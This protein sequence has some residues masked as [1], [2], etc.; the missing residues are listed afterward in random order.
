MMDN[1]E[2]STR[3]DTSQ[4]NT[5]LE[6]NKKPRMDYTEEMNNFLLGYESVPSWAEITKQFNSK[7]DMDMNQGAL[8]SHRNRMKNK[9]LSVQSSIA[10][11]SDSRTK[12]NGSIK[13][14][15]VTV[16][17]QVPQQTK[18]S[19]TFATTSTS[20]GEPSTDESHSSMHSNETHLEEPMNDETHLEEPMNDETHLEEP[21]NDETHFGE[22]VESLNVDKHLVL[23]NIAKRIEE[24]HSSAL[25]AHKVQKIVEHKDLCFSNKDFEMLLRILGA[26]DSE[27][28]YYLLASKAKGKNGEEL[29]MNE[30]RKRF[31]HLINNLQF[32]STK[33][34]PQRNGRESLD[35]ERQFLN[36]ALQKTSVFT[37]WKKHCIG[38]TFEDLIAVT[39]GSSLA[40]Y[41]E[42]IQR[43]LQEY[44]EVCNESISL[45]LKRTVTTAAEFSE[46][47][48]ANVYLEIIN[49]IRPRSCVRCGKVD[50][51]D[52]DGDHIKE[53]R[54]IL[55][56]LFNKYICCT[57][58]GEEP[59]VNFKDP[60]WA[61]NVRNYA[62]SE[63]NHQFLCRLECH[64]IK[65]KENEKR[66]VC[67]WCKDYEWQPMHLSTM[68]YQIVSGGFLRPVFS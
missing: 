39:K 37:S 57:R 53:K 18:V 19:K 11:D 66:C 51:N 35:L 38:D 27:M 23:Y 40:D 58:K 1:S 6:T 54:H 59:P 68:C 47:T 61:D 25:T 43:D 50:F 48:K 46:K 63:T 31:R 8:R 16:P 67:D 42:N 26:N 44:P 3:I 45:V 29:K 49:G 7:F 34:L 41:I 24:R 17:Q 14:F 55:M 62:K 33:Y 20:V 12:C 2:Y 28:D 65:T 15:L 56:C 52:C 9:K 10:T 32:T 36:L 13:R 21:M 4:D 60:N 22:V 64:P 5:T 30:Y